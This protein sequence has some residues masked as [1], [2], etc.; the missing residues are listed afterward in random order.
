MFTS[1]YWNDCQ[2]ICGST[3]SPHKNNLRTVMFYKHC[4][5]TLYSFLNSGRIVFFFDS[6]KINVAGLS[7]FVYRFENYTQMACKFELHKIKNGK[8]LNQKSICNFIP[9]ANL[10]GGWK[11]QSSPLLCCCPVVVLLSETEW[12][13]ESRK[14]RTKK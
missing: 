5:T 8:T 14:K 9:N 1:S 7:L 6:W 12:F 13:P 10:G 2:K 4:I 3:P 11:L